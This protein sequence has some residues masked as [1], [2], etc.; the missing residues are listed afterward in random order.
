M[1]TKL[2]KHLWLLVLLLLPS[3]VLAIDSELFDYNSLDLKVVIS[4]RFDVMPTSSSYLID[5][6]SAE[7]AW[8]PLDSFRQEVKSISTQPESKFIE[9]KGFFFE[10][11]KPSKTSFT[12]REEGIVTTQSDILRISRKIPFPIQDLDP[13]Y[14]EYLEAQ[15][16]IDMNPEIRLLAAD[17]VR[18][19]DDLYIAVYKLA[20]WVEKNVE[21]DLST[22]TADAT[23][24]SSWVLENKKGVCDEITNLFISLARS[25]GI[26]ARFVTGISYSNINFQNDGWGPHGWAEVY[27]PNIGWVP[28]D[29][30]YKEIGFIDA[31]HI[32]LKTSLDAQDSSISYASRSTN[33]EIVSGKIEFSV[34]VLEKDFL[35]R[36]LVDLEVEV[37]E[38][39]VGFNSYN[40]LIVTVKN[41]HSYYVASRISM[42]NVKDLTI[43]ED[44]FQPVLLAP[45][46]EK[47][48]YWLVKVDSGLSPRYI[49]TFPLRVKGSRGENA[50]TSF[51]VSD[52]WRLFSEEYMKMLIMTDQPEEKLYSKNVLVTCSADKNKIYLEQS[53]SLSCVVDNK[54]DKSLTRLDICLNDECTS[55]KIAQK[56][57]ATFDYTKTF[58]TLGMKTL[59][60]KAENALVEK[61][62]YTVID[63]QDKPAIE[64]TELTYPDYI[65]YDEQSEISFLI[66]KSST[67]VPMNIR[68]S[69]EHDLINQDW[70][71][72]DLTK[73]HNFRI[74]L[75]G[76]SL[77]L[78]KNDFKINIAYED[79]QGKQFN[80]EEDFSITL[81]DPD[82]FQKI[83]IWLNIAEYTIEG[84][85]GSD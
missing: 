2:K 7:L 38:P 81:K 51:Q 53:V 56:G 29:V 6:V 35:A 74:I 12:I 79:L 57:T 1:P 66:K 72:L 58:E 8:Y 64:I 62:Y 43:F 70:K 34:E 24:K 17:I 31:T 32:T 85:F 75:K 16:I 13:A 37:A 4:N 27:F 18:G 48:I 39:K 47:K 33:T 42:N 69:L 5:H 10:W 44:N 9:G 28:V 55:T 23:Q 40:L 20:M 67:S 60:F 21:Y 68:I 84:W 78:N 25:L 3:L 65:A 49:Y 80:I 11:I 15:E 19:E 54:G 22:M 46:E 45:R 82:F 71:L 73:P 77:K 41:H 76:K 50:E 14:S 83:M 61:S 59:V 30:T 26:P 52:E 36:P 63:V